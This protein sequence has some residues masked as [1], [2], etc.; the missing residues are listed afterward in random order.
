[1]GPNP[2]RRTTPPTNLPRKAFFNSYHLIASP[3]HPLYPLGL[4]TTPTLSSKAWPYLPSPLHVP[5]GVSV[6]MPA[7]SRERKLLPW[8]VTPARRKET[9]VLYNPTTSDNIH[10]VPLN[11]LHYPCLT[12]PYHT[13]TQYSCHACQCIMSTCRRLR[14]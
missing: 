12:L 9:G 3:A 4:P 6:V 5:P 2:R 1:M 14:H 7:G 11:S 13:I 8:A 10:Y